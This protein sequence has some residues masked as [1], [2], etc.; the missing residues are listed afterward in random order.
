MTN[1]A[2]QAALHDILEAI[3]E[4]EEYTEGLDFSGYSRDG[5]TRRSVERLIEIISEAS[6]KLTD[7]QKILYPSIQWPEIRAIGNLLRHRYGVVDDLVIWRIA[8]IS[9][10]ELKP[11]IQELIK[12]Q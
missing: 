7:D 2:A 12:K 5:K 10:M 8:S 1:R 9:L 4:I 3:A 6:R 11:A